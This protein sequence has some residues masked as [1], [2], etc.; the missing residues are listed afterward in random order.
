[1]AQHHVRNNESGCDGQ[2][3][4]LVLRSSENIG[5][6]RP[7]IDAAPQMEKVAVRYCMA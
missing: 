7:C 3:D 4:S 6:R 5:F 2:P 1:M